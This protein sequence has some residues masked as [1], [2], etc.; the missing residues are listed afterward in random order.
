MIEKFSHGENENRTLPSGCYLMK[1]HV[2]KSVLKS[3]MGEWTATSDQSME[4]A[5]AQSISETNKTTPTDALD[6]ESLSTDLTMDSLPESTRFMENVSKLSAQLSSSDQ[7]KVL[8]NAFDH[9]P[10]RQAE[11]ERENGTFDPESVEDLIIYMQRNSRLKLLLIMRAK[12]I[13]DFKYEKIIP[14]VSLSIFFNITVLFRIPLFYVGIF[15][16][17][18]KI[19]KYVRNGI[20]KYIYYNKSSL[21]LLFLI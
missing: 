5:D 8:L 14:I 1:V 11:Y 17:F 16:P 9:A 7:D 20:V 10:R 19:Y 13:E 6:D 4:D 2:S 21:L 12:K 18:R 3:L 15:F